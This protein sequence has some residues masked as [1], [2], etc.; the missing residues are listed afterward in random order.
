[1]TY[2]EQFKEVDGRTVS[3]C[4]ALVNHQNFSH[5]RMGNGLWCNVVWVY[6]RVPE[7]PSGVLVVGSTSEAILAQARKPRSAAPLSPTEPR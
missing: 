6:H 5:T 1:M 2:A 4:E 3:G 7:S